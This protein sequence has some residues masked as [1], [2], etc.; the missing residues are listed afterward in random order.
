MIRSKA[1]ERAFMTVPREEFVPPELRRDAYIDCP[2]P[3]FDTGQT[4]SAPHMV[5]YT[6]EKLD[7]CD[8]SKVLEVGG[9]SGYAASIISEIMNP[10]GTMVKCPKIVSIEIDPFLVDFAKSNIMRTKYDDRV[11]FLQGDGSKGLPQ[12]APFDRIVVSAA[13]SRAP[14]ALLEQLSDK[15]RMLIPLA[16]DGLPQRLYS[17][18]KEDKTIKKEYLLDVSFVKLIIDES[19]K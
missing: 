11:E 17:F 5:A 9:G 12:M 16:S 10:T 6:V 13:A 3:L 2:L 14:R 7:L 15:G 1:V 18:T 4:I 19:C 8:C